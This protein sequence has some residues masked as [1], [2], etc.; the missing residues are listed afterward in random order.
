MLLELRGISKHFSV[1]GKRQQV[2]EGVDLRVEKGEIVA[3]LGISGIGKT[4]L[5]QIIAGL[6]A[7]DA[8][9]AFFEGQPLPLRETSRGREKMSLIFQDPYAA[10]SP[11][12]RVAEIVGEPL[13]IRQRGLRRADRAAIVQAVREALEAVGLCP[14]ESYMRRYSHQLSGGQRQRVALA[15]ALITRPA[16]L[17]A[18]EPVSMLDVAVGV[19][20]L[21]LLRELADRGMAILFAAHDVASAAYIAD[22]LAVLAEGRIVEEGQPDRMARALQGE[23]LL[24]A[25]VW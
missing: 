7:A 11:H 22:R 19:D 21:N 2:L 16:L 8:G 25:P 10:L 6:L 1:G 17:L 23:R 9:E 15:R 20:V 12:L 5:L 24:G 3:L 14:A 4:T 13:V 18:D